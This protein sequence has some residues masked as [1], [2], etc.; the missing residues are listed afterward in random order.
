MVFL[1]KVRSALNKLGFNFNMAHGQ[2]GFNTTI[3]ALVV[4][5]D[6]GKASDLG[7][8]KAFCGATCHDSRS[9]VG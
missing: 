1:D 2:P 4:K 3:P 8:L 9:F 6:V 5:L 7:R